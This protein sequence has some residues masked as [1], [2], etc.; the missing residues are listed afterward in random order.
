MTAGTILLINV[1]ISEN[2]PSRSAEHMGLLSLRSSLIQ[3]GFDV[4]LFDFDVDKYDEEYLINV[5]KV[6]KPI[7]IGIS[8]STASYKT[9]KKWIFKW[10]K[11][12][13]IPIIIGG[14]HP[15]GDPIGTLKELK[16]DFIYRGD[17][18]TAIVRLSKKIKNK[19]TYF[20]DIPGLIALSDFLNNDKINTGIFLE[21]NLDKLPFPDRHVNKLSIFKNMLTVVGSRGCPHKCIFCYNSNPEL[22]KSFRIRSI[23]NI[24]NEIKTNLQLN[25]NIET[26]FF[27]DD[28]FLLIEVELL[29]Y[30]MN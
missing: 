24:I 19:E 13:T 6:N 11:S 2:N 12:T 5:I 17:G 25:P 28:C 8:L 15:T 16:P 7:L 20:A 30:L 29:N 9:A 4:L 21:K 3:S 23:S 14:P 26:I 22:K 27:L 18:E 1:P 10:K